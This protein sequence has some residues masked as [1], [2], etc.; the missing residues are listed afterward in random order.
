V[1]RKRIL[2]TQLYFPGDPGNRADGL[3]QRDLE[4]LMPKAAEGIYDFVVEA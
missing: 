3:Y 1:P 2:T 4:M